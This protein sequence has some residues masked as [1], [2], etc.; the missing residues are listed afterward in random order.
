MLGGIVI[1]RKRFTAL[2]FLA[3]GLLSLGLAVFTLA[4]VSVRTFLFSL[5][6]FFFYI[7]KKKRMRG[8][9]ILALAFS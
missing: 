9:P 3:S 1:Q 5:F 8:V 4:D 2:E 7:K 6:V